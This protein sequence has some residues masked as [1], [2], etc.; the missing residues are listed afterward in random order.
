M[1]GANGVG[2]V[3]QA[4]GNFERVIDAGRN[5]GMDRATGQPT[6]VYTVITNAA[7][8]PITTFPGRP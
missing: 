2:R 1:R 7:D 4:G 6:S 5:I 3:Q 8:E